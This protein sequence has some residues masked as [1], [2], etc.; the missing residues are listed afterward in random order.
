MIPMTCRKGKPVDLFKAR[1]KVQAE[2][3]DAHLFRVRFNWCVH[4]TACG[5]LC[6]YLIKAPGKALVYCSGGE[7]DPFLLL[8]ALKDRGFHCPRGLF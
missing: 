1:A 6:D 8:P 5:V 4:A 3:T 2:A 7:G